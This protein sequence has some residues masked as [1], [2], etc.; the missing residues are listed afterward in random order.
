MLLWI[1]PCF[2][3]SFF[4]FFFSRSICDVIVFFC[5]AVLP[6]REALKVTINFSAVATTAFDRPAPSQAAFVLSSVLQ[7]IVLL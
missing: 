3:S 4:S 1:S 2:L 5:A 7:H 6:F